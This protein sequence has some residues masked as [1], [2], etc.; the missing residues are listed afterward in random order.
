VEEEEEEV[1]IVVEVAVGLYCYRAY[2]LLKRLD[3]SEKKR[4]TKRETVVANEVVSCW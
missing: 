3:G 2:R 4:K 1:T